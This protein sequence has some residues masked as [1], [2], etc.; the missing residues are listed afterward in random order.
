MNFTKY[1]TCKQ[2]RLYDFCHCDNSGF[3]LVEIVSVIVILSIISAVV[4][5]RFYFSDSNLGA[6]TEAIKVY[7]RY[8]QVRSMNTESVWGIR[9][10][11]TSLWLYKD[12][13]ITSRVRLPGE[14]SATVD[15]DEKGISIRDGEAT[16]FIVSFNDWGKP[17]SDAA[18][19]DEQDSDRT[20]TVDSDAKNTNITITKNTGFI[21]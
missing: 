1:Q 17:C 8:A 18:A 20:L 19:T 5:S 11:G 9:C 12:G 7:L 4:A 21:P 14:D 15:L 16:T 13:D 3:T 6:Q 10:A 2:S